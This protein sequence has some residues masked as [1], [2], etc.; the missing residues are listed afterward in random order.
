MVVYAI[1]IALITLIPIILVNYFVRIDKEYAPALKLTSTRKIGLAMLILTGLVAILSPGYCY[2]STLQHLNSSFILA[3]L[4][5]MSYTDTHTKMLYSVVSAV[6]L[7][8]EI[9]LTMFSTENLQNTTYAWTLLIALGILVVIAIFNLIGAGDVLIYTVIMLYLLQN[10][11]VPTMSF[12]LNVL[13][14]NIMFV[15]VTVLKKLQ[16]K[17][18][19]ILHSHEPLTLFI[20][21]GTLMTICLYI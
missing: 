9:I 14:T 21:F 13:M 1:D 17:D 4:I 19:N 3:Y 20:Y 10:R 12:I 11:T 18:I 15:V 2:L 16:S 8:F 6:M 7:I 5:F